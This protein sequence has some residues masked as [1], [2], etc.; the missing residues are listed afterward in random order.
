MIGILYIAPSDGDVMQIEDCD[1]SDVR[2][3]LAMAEHRTPKLG[4]WLRAVLTALETRTSD[5]L[6]TTPT[7]DLTGW[8]RRELK[9]AHQWCRD[10]AKDDQHGKGI[11]R[12][13]SVVDA[14]IVGNW[15]PV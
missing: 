14:A 10:I 2:W 11:R 13:L 3:I 8:S 9:R 12:L 15:E 6:P 7:L 4:V 5:Y 1:L